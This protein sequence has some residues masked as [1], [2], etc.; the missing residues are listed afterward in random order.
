MKEDG[1]PGDDGL[2]AGGEA[3]R[4]AIIAWRYET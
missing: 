1:A 4:A 3:D 2:A